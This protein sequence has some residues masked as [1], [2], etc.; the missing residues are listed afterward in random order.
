MNWGST[1]TYLAETKLKDRLVTFGIKDSDRLEHVYVVGKVGSGRAQLLTRMAL[2]DVTKNYGA[3]IL[4]ATGNLTQLL[5]ERLDETAREKLIFLDPSDGEHPFSWNVV[6]EFRTLQG[7]RGVSLLKDALQSVYRVPTSEVIS[8]VASYMMRTEDSTILTLFNVVTDVARREK[9]FPSGTPERGLFE[10]ALKKEVDIVS[11]IAENGRYL[12]KDTLVRNLLGQ[13]TS[14]FS[15]EALRSGAVVV[16]DLSRIRMFPT[17]ITPLVRLFIHGARA[18][19]YQGSPLPIFLQDTLRYVD[20][21][22]IDQL[23]TERKIAFTVSDTALHEEDR[24]L[25]KK[26]LGRCG[27]LIAL[28]PHQSDVGLVEHMFYPYISPEDLVRLQEGELCAALT[29]DAVRSRPFFAR[30]LPLPQ[31]NNISAQDLLVVSRGKYTTPRVVVDQMFKNLPKGSD[32]PGGTPGSFTDAFRSIFTKR[33]GAPTEAKGTPGSAVSAK[34]PVAEKPKEVVKEVSATKQT[35]E[36]AES[37]LKEM[38]YV[39][40]IPA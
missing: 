24:P 36:I 31:R 25:R 33:A 12:A 21:E 15:L 7:G 27:S 14:K 29:I 9:A 6:D 8:I 1:I 40:P 39:G 5:L 22:E 37:V 10:E 32:E 17:R 3:I 11:A 28:S 35:S 19:A 38:L 2:Q 30:L 18:R 20:E 34:T 13:S 23:F 4:D 26:T 16:I